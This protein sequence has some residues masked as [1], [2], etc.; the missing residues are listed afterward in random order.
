M[1]H[2][3]Y[4]N[5]VG[6]GTGPTDRRNRVRDVPTVHIE[7]TQQ[8]RVR[9]CNLGGDFVAFAWQV[10]QSFDRDVIEREYFEHDCASLFPCAPGRAIRLSVGPLELGHELDQRVDGF[11]ANG[12]VDRCPHAAD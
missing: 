5:I 7:G 6:A 1:R 11:F 2:R 4:R 3:L 12:V 9:M 10:A 8:D